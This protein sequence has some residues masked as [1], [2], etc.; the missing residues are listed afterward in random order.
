MYF[1]ERILTE[2]EGNAYFES[3]SKQSY[4]ILPKSLGLNTLI[5]KLTPSGCSGLSPGCGNIATSDG[6]GVLPKF[7]NI[8][9]ILVQC[10]CMSNRAE[11]AKKKIVQYNEVKLDKWTEDL[12]E[13]LGRSQQMQFSEETWP[14][15]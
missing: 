7:C 5:P 12:V 14:H 9:V 4:L 1:L 8:S 11:L 6:T 13:D 3:I 10:A 2:C 15:V